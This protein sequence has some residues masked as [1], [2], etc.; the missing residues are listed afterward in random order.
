MGEIYPPHKTN[1][2]IE[3]ANGYYVDSVE[4]I[5]KKVMMN[6]AEHRADKV[7]VTGER[8][9]CRGIDYCKENIRRIHHEK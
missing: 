2:S 9:R 3:D 5:Y 8:V 6:E 1:Q 4:L 7:G